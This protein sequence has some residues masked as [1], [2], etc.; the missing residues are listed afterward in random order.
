MVV[1][2]QKHGLSAQQAFN[3][4]GELL[5][6]RYRGWEV[7]EARVPSWGE[8]VDGEVEKYIDGI[9]AVVQANLTWRYVLNRARL[10]PWLLLTAT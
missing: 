4:V 5:E 8:A 6:S 9:K 3:A 10:L 2:C 1:I 7:V